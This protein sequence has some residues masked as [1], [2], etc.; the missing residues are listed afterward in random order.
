[1]GCFLLLRK[2]AMLGDAIGHSVLFGVA[3]SF[4]LTGNGNTTFSLIGATLC[5]WL[6]GFIIEYLRQKGVPNDAAISVTFTTL[7]ALGVVILKT[8][9][10]NID[11]DLECALFG[12]LM[13]IPLDTLSMGSWEIPYPLTIMTAV[14]ILILTVLFFLYRP[15]QIS[16]FDPLL[17]AS[18]GLPVAFL[19]HVIMSLVSLTSVTSLKSGGLVLVISMLIIPAATAYLLTRHLSTMLLSSVGIGIMSTMTGYGLAI[20]WNI[21][22]SG[23]IALAAGGYFVLALL[24]SPHYGWIGYLCRQ[25][26]QLSRD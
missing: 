3:I 6:T 20:R 7:F 18:L 22:S 13:D 11:L 21:S 17:A 19:H 26:I 14:L 9:A 2:S 25:K 1:M 23:A 16:T 8:V 24:F 15:L 12:E 5:S 4:Y 10:N